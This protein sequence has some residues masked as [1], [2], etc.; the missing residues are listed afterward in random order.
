MKLICRHKVMISKT[1]DSSNMVFNTNLIVFPFQL[2]W[3]NLVLFFL[4]LVIFFLSWL[5]LSYVGLLWGLVYFGPDVW[6]V[7]LRQ[8]Y[9]LLVVLVALR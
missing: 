5:V 1:I 4:Y 2:F 9:R 6:V 8:Q 3:G 7:N